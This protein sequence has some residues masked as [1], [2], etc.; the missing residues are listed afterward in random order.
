LTGWRQTS[1]VVVPTLAR[2]AGTR[3]R[4]HW[5]GASERGALRGRVLIG[6][7]GSSYSFT[8]RGAGAALIG[9]RWRRGGSITVSFNG[10][11]KRVSTRAGK[12]LP[13]Q[14]LFAGAARQGRHTLSLVVNSG[15]V[16]VEGLALSDW[17]R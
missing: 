12:T 7:R 3:L 6:T 1:R 9:T 15:S 5:R 17:I 13:L 2:P 4:G 10:K 16:G 8:Y 14:R 11:R